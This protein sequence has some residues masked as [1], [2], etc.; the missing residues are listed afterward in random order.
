MSYPIAFWIGPRHRDTESACIDLH[1]RQ[2]L[3]KWSWMVSGTAVRPVP[4]L[5]RFFDEVLTRLP[6][7]PYAPRCL[8]RNPEFVK[9]AGPDF[10]ILELHEPHPEVIAMLTQLAAEHDVRG[11]D[12]AAHRLLAA[13]HV[14]HTFGIPLVAVPRR[15]DTADGGCAGLRTAMDQLELSAADL[16]HRG[17]FEESDDLEDFE[18]FDDLE[19]LSD[20]DDLDDE[21]DL[22]EEQNEMGDPVDADAVIDRISDHL[23]PAA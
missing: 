12:Q 22:W 19:D 4:R 14:S 8:W 6:D 20:L 1:L 17:L 9:G 18:D 2:C 11:L 15:G 21:N 10:L 3:A 7:E 23:G 5:A 13:E 16:D